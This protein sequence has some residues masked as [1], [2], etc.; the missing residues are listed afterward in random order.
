MGN[1]NSVDEKTRET[2]FENDCIAFHEFIDRYC[3]TEK[4][5]FQEVSLLQSAWV[6]GKTKRSYLFYD[7]AIRLGYKAT[8]NE[9][10]PVIIGLKLKEWPTDDI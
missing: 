6:T 2:L 9:H 10:C 5:A 1:S 3:I 4:S 8:G 7:I